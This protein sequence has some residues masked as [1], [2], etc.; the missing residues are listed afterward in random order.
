MQLDTPRLELPGARLNAAG[1]LG[2]APRKGE[3]GAAMLAAFV[4]NPI[5]LFLTL[6]IVFLLV[7]QTSFYR[8]WRG[9]E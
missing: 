1:S 5:S 8:R 7:S 9:L 3:A 6:A 2:F 4:T